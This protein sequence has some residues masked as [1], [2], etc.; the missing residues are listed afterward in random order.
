MPDAQSAPSQ[1]RL[2]RCSHPRKC[3]TLYHLVGIS[4]SRLPTYRRVAQI[5]GTPQSVVSQDL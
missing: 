4:T 1:P 3:V 5:T 2:V